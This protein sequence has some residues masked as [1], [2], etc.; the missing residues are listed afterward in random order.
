M[1]LVH[2]IVSNNEKVYIHCK[3]GWSR[4]ASVVISYLML[5]GTQK[6]TDT[7]MTYD[8]ALNIVGPKRPR[9]CPS[10]GFCILLED[11]SEFLQSIKEPYS[12][13]QFAEYYDKKYKNVKS[14]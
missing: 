3:M 10:F 4:S 13:G 8:E 9:I 1:D 7:K 11:L 2:S 5:H 12:K 6:N 14:K